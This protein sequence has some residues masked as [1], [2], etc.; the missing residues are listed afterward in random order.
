MLLDQIGELGISHIPVLLK[1]VIEWMDLKPG[2][3]VVDG[4]V[5]GGGHAEALLE[6]L[7]STGT[8]VAID[9]DAQTLARA[10]EKLRK[11][12]K[13]IH[14]VQGVFS[15][16]PQILKSLKIE[17]VQ[18]VL[19]DLGVSSFQL[20]EAE[21]GFSFLK[22]GPLDMRMDASTDEYE[23]ASDVVNRY[24]EE[25]LIE[26]FQK[27]GEER[28]SR[29]IAR[30][31]V[32]FRRDQPFHFT[33]DLANLIDRVVPPKF[34]KQ[35][36]RIHPATRVFQALRIVVNGELDHLE[37]FLNLDFEFLEKDGRLAL[38]SFHSLEDR[39]VKWRLREREDFRVLTKKPITASELEIENNPRSR[40]AKLRVAEKK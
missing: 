30:A 12:E 36:S 27:F 32:A 1:E 2:D 9:R 28:F 29:R 7:G 10:K 22:E 23:N 34:K 39:M 26:I 14:F 16:L 5:G 6:Q 21:R 37:K 18:G 3:V 4:T 20:D 25:E 35:A 40:S 38:I 17:K 15:D 24:S 8:Y 13:Q 11:Y 31:I 19:L 33:Q